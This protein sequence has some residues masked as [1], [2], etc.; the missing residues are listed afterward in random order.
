MRFRGDKMD[1]APRKHP[2]NGGRVATDQL[3]QTKTI[4][5]SQAKIRRNQI[6]FTFVHVTGLK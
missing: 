4:H 6:K 5:G 3:F 1:E 2:T